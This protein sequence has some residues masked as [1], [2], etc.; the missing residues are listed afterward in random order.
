M[1]ALILRVSAAVAAAALLLGLSAAALSG[2]ADALVQSIV[3]KDVPSVKTGEKKREVILDAGHGGEDGGAVS[4]SG[5]LEKD[6]NL[7]VVLRL[8][9][10]LT[11]CG[12]EVILTR[13][14]DEMLGGGA[15]GQRK[16]EDLKYRLKT[17]N[18][19][20][21]ALFLSVHM[22]KFPDP[23]CRGV[24]IYYSGNDGESE[25]F[26]GLLQ[27]AVRVLQ[28]GN[29]REMK[30]ATGAIYLLDRAQTPAALIECGFLSNPE[31][32]ALLK[33]E[34]YQ[35]ALCVAILAALDAYERQK[36]S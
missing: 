23:S 24:Q 26:A 17:A 19:H 29:R 10:L 27:E 32:E 11:L 3:A 25:R 21:G 12:Y 22:N 2:R 7:E 31:E 28:P 18:G 13:D 14:A 16:L 36:K 30:K 8:R 9:Q 6:L 33:D 4:S 34:N 20:P 1:K 35:E 15:R 5:T